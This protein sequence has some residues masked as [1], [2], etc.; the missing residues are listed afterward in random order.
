MLICFRLLNTA[1]Y[2]LQTL[3][4]LEEKLKSTVDDAFKEQITF[5]EEHDQFVEVHLP[6]HFQHI[7]HAE[8]ATLRYYQ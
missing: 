2:C 7:I 6:F 5:A 3:G 8:I 1:E 4:Q